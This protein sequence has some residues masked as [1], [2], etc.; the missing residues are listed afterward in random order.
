MKR[1]RT[2]TKEKPRS[3]GREGKIFF[4]NVFRAQPKPFKT[5]AMKQ[6]ILSELLDGNVAINFRM[7]ASERIN[8][9]RSRLKFREYKHHRFDFDRK[10]SVCRQPILT[11]CHQLLMLKCAQRTHP[12][13]RHLYI[14][15]WFIRPSRIPP[16]KL[17]FMLINIITVM[18]AKGTTTFSLNK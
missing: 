5:M 16:G 11:E 1:E 12:T 7:S 18:I 10:Q 6:R 3:K 8:L 9:P 4:L 13:H 2:K 17:T 15:E 14:A